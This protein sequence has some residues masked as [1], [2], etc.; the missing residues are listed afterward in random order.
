VMRYIIVDHQMTI[1][2]HEIHVLQLNND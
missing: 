2:V 1:A